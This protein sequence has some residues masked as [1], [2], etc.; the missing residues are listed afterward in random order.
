MPATFVYPRILLLHQFFLH[1]PVDL[2]LS[3]QTQ[4]AASA[5]MNMLHLSLCLVAWQC[6][7]SAARAGN[8][9]EARILRDLVGLA[10]TGGRLDAFV[11]GAGTGGTIA[12]VSR[13]LKARDPRIKVRC[14][15]SLAPAY[16]L[17]APGYL[18]HYYVSFWSATNNA[19][20]CLSQLTYPCHLTES[21]SEVQ[22][23]MR[24]KPQLYTQVLCVL[25]LTVP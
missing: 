5:T 4:A 3:I 7:I 13:Y 19:H 10:Q 20:Q 9:A 22:S 25:F 24:C 23:G 6:K 16:C 15:S 11:S 1:V 2:R 21:Q 14:V 17:H 8:S 18:V 12:G